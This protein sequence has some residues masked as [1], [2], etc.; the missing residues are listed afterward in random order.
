MLTS[1]VYLLLFKRTHIWLEIFIFKSAWLL[2]KKWEEFCSLLIFTFYV[3]WKW[4]TIQALF[5]DKRFSTLCVILLNQL[6]GVFLTDKHLFIKIWFFMVLWHCKM[7][8]CTIC[9]PFPFLSAPQFSIL[10]VYCTNMLKDL[11]N[12]IRNVT[13]LLWEKKEN[14]NT[15]LTLLI[16]Y[17]LKHMSA[18]VRLPSKNWIRTAGFAWVCE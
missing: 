8:T 13:V 18:E 14:F 2:V 15:T 10:Y 4:N 1:T 5:F 6:F 17:L 3:F 16:F 11:A 12:A 9:C 7:Y